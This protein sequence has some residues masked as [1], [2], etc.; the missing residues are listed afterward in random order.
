[1][2]AVQRHQHSKSPFFYSHLTKLTNIGNTSFVLVLRVNYKV[3]EDVTIRVVFRHDLGT[4]SA[5]KHESFSLDSSIVA[6]VECHNRVKLLAFN[7][8]SGTGVSLK[9]D[10]PHKVPYILISNLGA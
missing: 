8:S 2:Y 4:R 1:M 9:T 6:V 10:I 3:D 7:L 5:R